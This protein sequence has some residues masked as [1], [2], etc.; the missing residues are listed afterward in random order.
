MQKIWGTGGRRTKIFCRVF[1][2]EIFL[3]FF[4]QRKIFGKIFRPE[5][6]YFFQGNILANPEQ[7]LMRSKNAEKLCPKIGN[8]F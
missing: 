4:C 8:F 7:V 3:A 1:G 2:L 5:V 6:F